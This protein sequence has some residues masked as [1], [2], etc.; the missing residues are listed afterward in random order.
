MG[1]VRGG[2]SPLGREWCW[3]WSPGILGQ[4][5]TSLTEWPARQYPCGGNTIRSN[6]H[7]RPPALCTWRAVWG[8]SKLHLVIGLMV[9]KAIGLHATLGNQTKMLCSL[10]RLAWK[11]LGS[12]ISNRLKGCYCY[13]PMTARRASVARNYIPGYSSHRRTPAGCT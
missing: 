11:G 10:T 1:T 2:C 13:V 4:L 7:W 12:H 5:A 3:V 9:G 8:H 6:N